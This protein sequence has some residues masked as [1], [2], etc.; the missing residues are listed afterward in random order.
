MTINDDPFDSKIIV[1]ERN[2]LL[3]NITIFSLSAR[4]KLKFYKS[5]ILIRIIIVNLE[6]N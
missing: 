1:I 2:I 3:R 4:L 5:I 6:I